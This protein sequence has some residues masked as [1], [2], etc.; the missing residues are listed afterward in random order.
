MSAALVFV[1]TSEAQEPVYWDVIQK[2]RV[3]GFNHSQ[4]MK[5][6]SYITDVHGPRL[7][8]SPSY[9]RAAEWAKQQFE[10]FGLSNVHLDSYGEFGVT[11]S[12]EY[13]SVHM[14]TPEYMPIIAYP[15][16]FSSGTNRKV[17]GQAVFININSISS[18]AD[19]NAFRGKL[20][21]AVV[22]IDPK[23][24][25][26][27]HF[28]PIA[29]RYTEEQLDELSQAVITPPEQGQI[30]PRRVQSGL[31]RDEIIDFLFSEGTATIVSPDRR[32]DYGTVEV[33]EVPGRA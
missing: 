21:D 29:V 13:T 12:N 24:E 2:I 8:N 1:T 16:T 5:I 33:S 31:S 6:A 9:Q 27:P 30:N 22:F 25:M 23:V 3:E 20:R 32:E 4:I 28:D 7:A 15:N 10:E 18:R 26:S 11:W 14:M 17:R 19:L